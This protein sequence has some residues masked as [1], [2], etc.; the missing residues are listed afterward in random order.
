MASF[1]IGRAFAGRKYQSFTAIGTCMYPCLKQ[2]DVLF[3]DNCSIESAQVGDIAVIRQ[4]GVL[5]GH[6]II[7]IGVD[8]T[9]G[10]FI[11][12]RPDRTHYDNDAPTFQDG[13]LGIVSGAE[14]NGKSLPLDALKPDWLDLLKVKLREWMHWR[15]RPVIVRFLSRIQQLLPYR[16]IASAYLRLRYPEPVVSVRVPLKPMQHTDFFQTFSAADFNLTEVQQKGQAVSEWSVQLEFRKKV[17]AASV[18]FVH[19]PDGCPAGGGWYLFHSWSRNRYRGAGLEACLI[20]EARKIFQ[21]S[22]ASFVLNR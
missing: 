8:D 19:H 16:L 18:T 6:R 15:A 22:G 5:K 1:E 2:G 4:N 14:R 7:S 11:V 13:F 10:V 9:L 12:T 21:R 3:I 17:L 20:G